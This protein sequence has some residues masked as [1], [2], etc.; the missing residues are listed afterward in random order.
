[1][2]DLC[3]ALGLP[4]RRGRSTLLVL[5]CSIMLMIGCEALLY[6]YSYPFFSL[7]MEERGYSAVVIGLNASV[8]NVGIFIVG[9]FLPRLIRGAGVSTVVFAMFSVSALCFMA[10]IASDSIVTWFASRLVMGACFAAL[11][12]CTE[13]WLNGVAPES[14]RGRLIGFSSVVYGFFQFVGPILVGVVGVSGSIPLL[15]AAGPLVLGAFLALVTA[16]P[17]STHEEDL[18]SEGIP[19]GWRAMLGAAGGL[20]A[21]AFAAGVGETAMQSMLPLYGLSQHLSPGEAANLVAV[22]SLGEAILV[23]LL[24]WL[25]DSFGRGRTIKFTTALAVLVLLALPA[26]QAGSAAGWVLLFIAGGTV[27]GLY[28]L[29]VVFA[30]QELSGH[31][32]A[33]AGTMLAMTY[34][35]GSII[36]TVP[37]G[38]MFDQ[39]GPNA[40][41]LGIAAMFSA[42]F[43][44]LVFRRGGF[45]T[46]QAR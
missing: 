2:R 9:P 30:G 27:S 44:I 36:G 14:G 25:S 18:E 28:A 41:P 10:L 42:L 22:F 43:A 8:G 15:V 7:A 12:T 29:A 26:V 23:F 46:V 13:Y 6:G 32:L 5:I 16:A 45:G 20:M 35:V 11:W 19:Q 4:R 39:F 33:V 17:R 21:L 31:N 34:S 38:L 1:M 40:L 3:A 37:M 24:G